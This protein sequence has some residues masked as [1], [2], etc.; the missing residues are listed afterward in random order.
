M[1]ESVRSERNTFLVTVVLGRILQV[2]GWI[3]SQ[4]GD[5]VG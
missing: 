2:E 4:R 3:E 5:G 1:R